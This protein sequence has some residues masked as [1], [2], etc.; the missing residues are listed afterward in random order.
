MDLSKLFEQ[1]NTQDSYAILFIILIAFL[2]GLLL[3]YILRSRRVMQLRRE[4]KVKEKELA[5]AQAQAEALEEQLGLKEA[6]LKKAGFAVQEAETRA[7]RVEEEKGALHK[8]IFN[9]NRQIDELQSTQK[10]NEAAIE[11]LN[12]TIIGLQ[13]RNKQLSETLETEDAGVEGLAQMQS[14]YNATRQRLEAVEERLER[15]AGENMHLRESLESLKSSGLMAAGGAPVAVASGEETE[16]Q[17]PRSIHPE[18]GLPDAGVIDEEPEVAVGQEK[19]FLQDKIGAA[20]EVGE[21]DDLTRIAGV[22]PFL[23]KKLNEIGVFTYEEIASWDSSRVREV[24]EAIQYFEGRI[25]RDNWVE[26]AARLAFMKQENPEAFQGRPSALSNDPEDL[27]IIEGIGPKI[28]ELLKTAGIGNWAA[29]AEAEVGLLRDI[30][31]AAGSAYQIH[32]PSTWP[33]QA[34]LAVNGEWGVLKEYQAEL[35]GGRETDREE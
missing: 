3:G 27:K 2:F 1:F 14:V 23:E 28:E 21:K 12:T 15:L 33:T 32:D 19:P 35:H 8:E 20:A 5:D 18:P 11:E 25:E 24:T 17:E 30:L 7:A 6:D 31:E 34:R 22:G 13:S 9:L 4:L 26:Q 16:R 10:S 29:L